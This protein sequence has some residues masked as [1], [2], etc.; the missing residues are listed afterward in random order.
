MALSL[1]S[2]YE[3]VT[4]IV[5]MSQCHDVTLSQC[6]VVDCHN[7]QV[8]KSIDKV[9]SF[10]LWTVAFNNLQQLDRFREIANFIISI[11]KSSYFEEL[12]FPVGV[13]GV[14][15]ELQFCQI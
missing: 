7:V 11:F 13:A 9:E 1:W 2:M 15:I 4:F 8:I 5:T 12:P 3:N 10:R 6:M 14:A